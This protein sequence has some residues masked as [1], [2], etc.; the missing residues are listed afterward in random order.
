M[1]YS[2]VMMYLEREEPPCKKTAISKSDIEPTALNLYFPTVAESDQSSY[3]MYPPRA[4]HLW[5]VAMA[6]SLTRSPLQNRCYP[7]V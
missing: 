6:P 4:I 3:F 2:A 7:S 5:P 1:G